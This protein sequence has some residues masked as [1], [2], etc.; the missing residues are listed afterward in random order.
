WLAGS[1][2]SVFRLHGVLVCHLGGFLGGV[3]VGFV[4]EH[5]LVSLKAERDE[6]RKS[7]FLRRRSVRVAYHGHA[8]EEMYLGIGIASLAPS[9]VLESWSFGSLF[10]SVSWFL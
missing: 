10:L 2:L 5:F 1:D 3:L 8:K 7:D 9:H 4:L 6:E